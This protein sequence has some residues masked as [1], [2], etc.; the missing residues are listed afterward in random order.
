MENLLVCIEIDRQ[1]MALSE[2]QMDSFQDYIKYHRRR[3]DLT[4]KELAD[5]ADIGQSYVSG[6]ERGINKEPTPD[7]LMRIAGAVG[8]PVEEVFAAAGKVYKGNPLPPGKELRT[9]PSGR[10]AYITTP[11]GEPMKLDPEDILDL[12]LIFDLL[13]K[14]KERS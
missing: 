10:Q 4:Q 5:K 2:P 7:I 11:T 13:E 14:R 8:R 9:F 1:G 3:L 12:D 6:L